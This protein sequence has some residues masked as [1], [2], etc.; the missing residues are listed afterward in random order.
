MIAYRKLS[1]LLNNTTSLYQPIQ[2]VHMVDSR[3]KGGSRAPFELVFQPPLSPFSLSSQRP[4]PPSL[5][6]SL[7]RTTLRSSR[8]LPTLPAGRRTVFFAN[9]KLTST[10]PPSMQEQQQ[11]ALEPSSKPTTELE[12]VRQSQNT[13]NLWKKIDP[14]FQDMPH[15]EREAIT[16]ILQTAMRGVSRFL[17]FLSPPL[18]SPSS[19][20]L[21]FRRASVS[22][23]CA[24]S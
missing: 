6:M 11:Q 2:N 9:Y 23:K 18:L 17:P 14:H 22:G 15:H 24:G 4:F 16:N 12:E 3:Q 7:L 10:D 20:S 8:A 1:E 5:T 19:L 21:S 13:K